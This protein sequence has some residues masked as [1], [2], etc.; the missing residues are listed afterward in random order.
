M[1]KQNERLA[2]SAQV[3]AKCQIRIEDLERNVMLSEQKAKLY[4]AA[5][6]RLN[7]RIANFGTRA[8]EA[9]KRVFQLQ[10]DT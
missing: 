5:L 6:G 8:L 2:Q 4:L 10:E 1:S 7:F 3:R 9:E